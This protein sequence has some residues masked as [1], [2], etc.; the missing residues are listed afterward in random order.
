MGN[1]YHDPDNGRFTTKNGGGGGGGPDVASRIREETVGASSPSDPAAGKLNAADAKGKGVEKM[2]GVKATGRM[3]EQTD[4][5]TGVKTKVPEYDFSERAR[6]VDQKLQDWRDRG[7]DTQ[8]LYKGK[9]GEY[10]ASRRKA[11]EQLMEDLWKRQAANVPNEGK[12]IMAG[13]L[14]GAGKGFFLKLLGIKD[15]GAEDGSNYFTINPDVIKEEMAKR[16]MIPK[17]DPKMTLMELSP[18]AHEEASMMAMKLAKRAYAQKKNVVWDFTMSTPGS[19]T[20][21]RMNLMRKA[22]YNNIQGMFVDV[23]VDKSVSQ[24]KS[25]WQN[26]LI[27]Y[28]NEGSGDGGRFLPSSATA[29]NAPVAGDGPYRSKNRQTFEKIKSGLDGYRIYDNEDEKKSLESK[30]IEHKNDAEMGK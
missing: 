26:G 10:T 4:P 24:A 30:L 15:R 8:H 6:Y 11:Q 20:D 3:I 13:G 1:P 2:W 28:G 16:G 21:K 17:L 14:G 18:L 19:V 7:I 25:R 22:G 5:K 29:E 23:S 12:A 27:R 9:N